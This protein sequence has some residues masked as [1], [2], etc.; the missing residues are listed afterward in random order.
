[1]ARIADFFDLIRAWWA[2]SL[3]TKTFWCSGRTNENKRKL[4][5]SLS[6]SS[7]DFVVRVVE[8]SDEHCLHL[9]GCYVNGSTIQSHVILFDLGL[10]AYVLLLSAADGK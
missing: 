10:N 1:L 7:F 3:R 6:P 4:T 8:P 9:L 2:R 5:T